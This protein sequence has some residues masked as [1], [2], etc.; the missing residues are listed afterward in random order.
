M[1]KK[2]LFAAVNL[3]LVFFFES[4]FTTSVYTLDYNGRRKQAANNSYM[5]SSIREIQAIWRT[6]EFVIIRSTFGVYS[7]S[8]FKDNEKI[9]EEICVPLELIQTYRQINFTQNKKLCNVSNEEKIPVDFMEITELKNAL[10]FQELNLAVYLENPFSSNDSPFS[11]VNLFFSNVDFAKS[12]IKLKQFLKNE[13][14]TSVY[15]TT[16]K[17]VQYIWIVFDSNKALQFYKSYEGYKIVQH[18]SK[19]QWTDL[20]ILNRIPENEKIQLRFQ[21]IPSLENKFYLGFISE[22]FYSWTIRKSSRVFE[23]KLNNVK[24]QKGLILTANPTTIK[25]ESGFSWT[26]YPI[27]YP[28]SIGLDIATSPLQFLSIM[29]LGFY[30]HLWLGNCIL[31]VSCK[32]PLG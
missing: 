25:K 30:E 6:K 4:C 2:F 9:F 24:I 8:N 15:R 29:I 14:I 27:L 5:N 10:W 22:E 12:K 1:E 23:L 3:L 20:E 19:L 28:V 18:D 31:K 21:E 7:V 17:N 32:T 11:P 26:F 13:K 16:D